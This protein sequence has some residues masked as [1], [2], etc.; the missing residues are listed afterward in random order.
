MTQTRCI[1]MSK[2]TRVKEHAPALACSHTEI[3]NT[4]SISTTTVVSW[5][6]PQSALPHLFITAWVSPRIVT[7]PCSAKHHTIVM[8]VSVRT[9]AC[10]LNVGTYREW[11]DSRSGWFITADKSPVFT[12]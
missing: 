7:S 8:C 11:L 1:W 6:A 9:G 4:Y 10:T 5:K 2:A 3:F 12:Y